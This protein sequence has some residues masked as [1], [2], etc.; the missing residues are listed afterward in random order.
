[1]FKLYP[2][3]KSLGFNLK[4][5]YKFVEVIKLVRTLNK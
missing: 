1:M 3:D 5:L 2:K 4:N